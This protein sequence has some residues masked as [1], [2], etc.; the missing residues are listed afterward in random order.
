DKRL[1]EQ[2]V[3]SFNGE[4]GARYDTANDGK[5]LNADLNG[6]NGQFNWHLDGTRRR[7]DS[8]D[9][10][11]NAIAEDAATHGT[12]DNSQLKLDEY[13]GGVGYTG[14]NG[15]IGVSGVR[16]ESNYGIPGR[17]EEGAPRYHYR[18]QENSLAVAWR[19]IKPIC[20]FL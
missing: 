9:I 6:G 10:P 20:G 12:V 8:Y 19:F 11:G 14:D 18:S 1:H 2:P 4:V 3:D 16:T 13:A 5:T 15:F 7:T 17:G